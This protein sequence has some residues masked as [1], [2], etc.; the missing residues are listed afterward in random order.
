M[1]IL[2]EVETKMHKDAEAGC[3][4]TYY[5]ISEEK[6]DELRKKGFDV[7]DSDKQSCS[8]RV[9]RID[10]SQAG[11]D[12]FIGVDVF[13][14]NEKNEEYTHAEQLW[15]ISSQIRENPVRYFETH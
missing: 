15:I 1:D 12:R 10:W 7:K 14:L 5:I 2:N 4:N 3:Y 11:V 9:F 13:S 8:P 6:A